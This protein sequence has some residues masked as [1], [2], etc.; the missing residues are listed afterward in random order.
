MWAKNCQIVLVLPTQILI[1]YH[2][3]EQSKPKILNSTDI[4]LCGQ[5]KW[6]KK[7]KKILGLTSQILIYYCVGK[8]SKP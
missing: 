5:A 7:Y 4:L 2:V 3:G 8:Q 1:Y 6:A